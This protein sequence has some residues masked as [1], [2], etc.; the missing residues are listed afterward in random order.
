MMIC[1][2]NGS[3]KASSSSPG[4]CCCRWRW[5]TPPRHLH[6]WIVLLL[7]FACCIADVQAGRNRDHGGSQRGLGNN[8]GAAGGSMDTHQSRTDRLRHHQAADKYPLTSIA[9][10]E[11]H[12]EFMKGKS[13]SSSSN[14]RMLFECWLVGP[15][16]CLHVC[17]F[18][19]SIC[20][21][22]ILSD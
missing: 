13:E 19:A 15:S 10:E 14:L 16:I 22:A 6:I 5:G 11:Q 17:R 9:K 8:G 4:C 21:S 18:D 12:S 1:P 3:C 7:A 2:P 20:A